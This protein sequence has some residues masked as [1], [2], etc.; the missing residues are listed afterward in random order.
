MKKM[1]VAL[2]A[3]VTLTAGVFAQAEV[4]EDA[5]R[6]TTY[7]PIAC[8]AQ[9]DELADVV[10]LRLSAWS[11]CQNMTGLDLAIGGEA[12]NAYGLQLALVRNKVIDTAGAVQLAL[13]SNYAGKLAGVQMSLLNDAI[14]AKGVQLGLVNQASDVRGLQLGLINTTDIIYGYQLGLINVI[15]GSALPCF[16]IINFMLFDE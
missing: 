2:L 13:V 15:K 14:V 12:T 8:F 6:M 5:P 1:I 7:S 10:G 16:P 4:A 9:G 11:T 3:S